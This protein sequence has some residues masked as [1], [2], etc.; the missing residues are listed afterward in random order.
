LVMPSLFDSLAG[1]SH[2]LVEYVNILY[3]YLIRY[4][5]Y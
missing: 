4:I 1:L 3:L 2:S 5:V